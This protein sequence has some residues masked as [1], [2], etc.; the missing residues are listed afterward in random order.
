MWCHFKELVRDTLNF[1][2]RMAA[3]DPDLEAGSGRCGEPNFVGLVDA[4]LRRLNNPGALAALPLVAHLPR[5]L[6]SQ[7]ALQPGSGYEEV[8]P[9]ERARTLREI[10]QEAIQQLRPESE[11]GREPGTPEALQFEILADEYLRAVPTRTISHRLGISESTLHRYRR[12]AIGH[13]AREIEWREKRLGRRKE[14][15]FGAVTRAAA[16]PESADVVAPT[17]A[18]GL[19]LLPDKQSIG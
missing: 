13:L 15:R 12:E 16:I 9:L 8:S 2:I 17:L 1:A 19:R 10:F 18:A 14:L 6:A 4:A 11:T 5:T 3:L 7:R